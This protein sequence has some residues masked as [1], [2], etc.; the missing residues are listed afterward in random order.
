MKVGEALH[1]KAVIGMVSVGRIEDELRGGLD[2]RA[3]FAESMIGRTLIVI[4]VLAVREG[5]GDMAAPPGKAADH[6]VD[7]IAAG[8]GNMLDCLTADRRVAGNRV[9]VID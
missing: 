5:I 2:L 7:E 4:V 1:R 8:V 3:D 6:A 9:V